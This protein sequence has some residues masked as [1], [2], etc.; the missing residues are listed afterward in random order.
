MELGFV[1]DFT[2]NVTLDSELTLNPNTGI[3][4]NS[5]V[6]TSITLDNLLHFLPVPDLNFRIYDAEVTY[7]NYSKSRSKNDIVLYQDSIYQC[8]ADNIKGVLPTNGARWLK[9]NEESLI[10]KSFISRVK[11]KVIS[12]LKLSKRLVNAQYLYDVGRNKISLPGDYTAWVFEPKGSDY[13]TI[14]I[15]EISCQALTADPVTMYVINQNKLIDT[16][17]LHPKNGLLEFEKIG[18]AFSGPGKWIFAINSQDVLTSNSWIDEQKYDGFV[19]YTSTGTGATVE[20]S[21]WNIT[22]NSNG[23]GFNVSVTMDSDKYIQYNFLNLT[24]FIKTSFELMSMHL[25]LNNSNQRSNRNVQMNK[26]MLMFETKDL[27]GNTVA[28]RYYSELREAKKVI[29]KTFD[30][31]LSGDW[32]IETV[33]TS[34]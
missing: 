33:T 4:L 7:N 12:D 26:D 3:I 31:Q 1:E 2:S 34:V 11:D 32:G 10:L 14:T 25:F 23:L 24:S 19:C 20:T 27:E 21:D 13:T 6:H 18:Y 16:I 15:N 28:K 9:T 8:L 29:Q 22:N 5:G 30:T 17:I